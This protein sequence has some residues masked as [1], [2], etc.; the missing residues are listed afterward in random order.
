MLNVLLIVCDDLRPE[1][2]ASY[3]HPHM[4]T[5]RLDELA[6]TSLVFERAY[7]NYAY[8][9]PSRNSFM[10]GRMPDTS[11]VYNF[12]DSF[13]D[14]TVKDRAGVPGT[15]WTTLPQ[16]F[17]NHGFW[18]VGSGKLFHPDHPPR[19]DNPRSWSINFT[20][21]GENVGCGCAGVDP[22][23]QPANALPMYCELPE[24]TDCPDVVIASTVVAQLRQW[25]TTPK[26]KAKPFF[27]A[28]GIHKPH[29]PWGAPK[30]FFNAYPKAAELP[31]AKY[32]L[33]PVGMPAVAY[34]HCQW[35]PFPWNSS[36]GVPI[37]DARAHDAR[38]AYY[39]AISFA[40]HLV[41]TVLDELEAIGQTERTVV[42]F[43]SDHGWQ[44]GE[45]N[46]WC[47]ETVFE[48]S[49]RIPFM[50]RDPRAHG[51]AVGGRSR[52]F[53]ENIDIYRT[54]AE[55]SGAGAVEP[56][57]DGASLAP[58]LRVPG[59]AAAAALRSAKGAAYGQHARCLRNVSDHYKP[60]S[61]WTHADSCTVTPR[62]Q[63]D[64]MGYSVRT[65][66]WRFTA[67]VGWNGTDLTPRWDVLNATELYAHTLSA[68][69]PGD[70]DF[71]AWENVNVAAEPK[72]AKVAGRLMA[73]LRAHF[74]AFALPYQN[75]TITEIL[76]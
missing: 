57:V 13:R 20:D 26:L 10:S 46:E 7:T 76:C 54:L 22:A 72:H 43:S 52:V 6:S 36:Q 4:I 31:L 9:C 21:P 48:L 38:R 61:P 23:T 18:T 69:G 1:L 27:A 74:E 50:I 53:A 67:W 66:D 35:G 70:Q 34:H 29:L 24:S 63:L 44:L 60:I 55:L 40:D 15:S 65:D 28:L 71:D 5:P 47:K 64:W 39:S 58:L 17:K 12:I 59:G 30:K 16:H 25:S 42:L 56:G 11:K 14:A 68:S 37:A 32:K 8:C 41:G 2:N 62:S 3:G 73:Q 33:A 45:H 19:D 51:A 49:L 75:S